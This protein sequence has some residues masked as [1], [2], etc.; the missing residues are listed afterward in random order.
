MK[1]HDPATSNIPEIASQSSRAAIEHRQRSPTALRGIIFAGI[2]L[3]LLLLLLFALVPLPGLRLYNTPLPDV[4]SWTLA[5]S[6]WLFPEA[7]SNSTHTL[8]FL[9]LLAATLLAL[10]GTYALAIIIVGRA[11]PG[12]K[13]AGRGWLALLLGGAL[14]FGITLLFLPRLFSD[15]VFSYIFS[16]RIL[17]IYHLDPL[18]TAPFQFPGDPYLRWLISGRAAPNIYGPLWLCITSLLVGVSS[19]LNAGPVATLL[20]FKGVMLFAH[21]CNCLLLWLILGRVAPARRLQG[22]LLYAWNP[23]ALLELAGAGH[24]EGVLLTLFLLAVFVY[25]LERERTDRRGYGL[26]VLAIFGLAASANLVALLITPL[27]VWFTLRAERNITRAAW[28]FCWRMILVLAC[29][30]LVYLPFWRGWTTFFAI[31]S[32][33]DMAHFVHSPLGVLV[34]PTRGFFSD[35]ARWAHFPPIMEPVAAADLTLRGSATVIFALIYLNLFGRV[36][37]APLAPVTPVSLATSGATSVKARLPGFDVLLTCWCSAILAYLFLVSGWFWPWFVLW[38]LWI[39]VMRRLDIL[40]VTV[41]LLSG[42]ALFVYPFMDVTRRSLATYFPV[43]IFGLPLV[44]FLIG[45]L[46]KRY[47]RGRTVERNGYD[48]RSQ[49]AKD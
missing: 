43:L 4:W 41:L 24:Y 21:L 13:S 36:R 29:M 34:N 40:T 45:S 38:V 5:L 27:F 14:I 18:N 3:E 6:R 39:V 15:D 47:R 1:T 28:A 7:W 9:V 19:S 35:V 12:G 33:I 2:I 31:T 8:P 16:G 26:L 37:L 44:Y 48:G 25:V 11:K 42:T 49:A 10:V 46:V 22:T 20:L 32:A 17:S 30:A 23:L